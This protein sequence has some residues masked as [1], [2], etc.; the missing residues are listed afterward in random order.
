[1]AHANVIVIVTSIRRRAS[2]LRVRAGDATISF[3]E[4]EE[5]RAPSS[6]AA[7]PTRGRL[8]EGSW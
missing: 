4:T 1:M 8:F 7:R 6:E 5:Q 3:L 2:I